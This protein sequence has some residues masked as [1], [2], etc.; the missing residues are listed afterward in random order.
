MELPKIFFVLVSVLMISGTEAFLPSHAGRSLASADYTLTDI[1]VAGITRMVARY[2]EDSNPDRYSPG[3]LTGLNPMTPSHLYQV[4]YGLGKYHILKTVLAFEKLC[5]RP[6]V[7]T[8][9]NYLFCFAF[10][11]LDSFVEAVCNI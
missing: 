3:D 10:I 11:H 1:T 6:S 4:H 8:S 5:Y 9:G 7:E 2:F